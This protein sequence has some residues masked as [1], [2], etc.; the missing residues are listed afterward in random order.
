MNANEIFLRPA[1]KQD[2]WVLSAV[3]IAAIKALPTTF[4]TRQELLA[5]RNHLSKPDGSH[6][7]KR[8]KSETFWVA[9]E[10]NNIVGFTSYIV[11]ELIAL[12]VHPHYQGRG[13][14][15]AL[16]EHFFHQATQQKVDK[17]I[18]TA[19]L[20]AEGFYLRLGFNTIQKAPHQLNKG[21]IVPVVKMSKE[22][23]KPT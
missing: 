22:L 6:I 3:H 14:G 19:S 10:G 1:E 23:I 8:M 12:Y 9:V 7:L 16:V 11:D 18:T 21:V 4:Y 17:V 15:R 2:A 5:W 20:Y 13:N